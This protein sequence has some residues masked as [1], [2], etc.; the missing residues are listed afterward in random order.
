MKKNKIVYEKSS[1]N[2]FKDLG[3]ENPDLELMRA[4]LSLEIFKILE[5]RK[6]TQTEAGKLLG[7]RQP[8]VSKLMN[9]DY[10]RF[11]VERLMKFI[12]QLDRDIEIRIKKHPAR[13]KEPAGVHIT[14]AS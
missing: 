12:N 13:S 3:F 8:D 10:G 11:S 5:K 9:G 14:A 4:R 1:G 6:L 2:V 7:I